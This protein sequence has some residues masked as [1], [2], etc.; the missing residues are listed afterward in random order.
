MRRENS[1]SC[2]RMRKKVLRPAR[3]VILPMGSL[4]DDSML[5]LESFHLDHE[6]MS[7]SLGPMVNCQYILYM[8]DFD[9]G[10]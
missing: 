5:Q 9:S 10:L 6:A 7:N 1:E 2:E 8:H 3:A 4:D